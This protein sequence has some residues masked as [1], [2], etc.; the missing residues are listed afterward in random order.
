M[1]DMQKVTD[2]LKAYAKEKDILCWVNGPNAY[3]EDYNY[4]Y[5]FKNPR[6]NYQWEFIVD[7]HRVEELYTSAEDK[8]SYLIDTIK[9]KMPEL[10][11]KTPRCV[12]K[13]MRDLLT[14]ATSMTV[15]I[16]EDEKHG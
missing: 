3:V 12:R 15:E 5:R 11:F 1:I 14:P 2:E 6:N 10:L 7:E 16:T 9:S 8:T 13:K 4:Y